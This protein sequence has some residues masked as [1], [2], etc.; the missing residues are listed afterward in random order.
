MAIAYMLIVTEMGAEHDAADEITKFAGVEEVAITYGAWDL[1]VR[2]FAESLPD[3]DV[4]VT[5]IRRLPTV[6]ET[7]TL[8]G[9]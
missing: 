5:K 7:V 1:V 4:I 8:I 3:L 9:K 6:D 2:I